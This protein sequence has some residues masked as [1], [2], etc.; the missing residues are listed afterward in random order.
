MTCKIRPIRIDGQLA[1]VPLTKGYEAVIDAADVPLVDAWIWLAKVDGRNVYA[2]RL[3][4]PR[5]GQR[6]VR[7]HRVI[8]GNPEGMQV[9]HIDCNGLNN[10]R[11]NLRVATPS[12]NQYN[13]RRAANNSS[14]AKGVYWHKGD[15]RWHAQIRANNVKYHLGVFD[16]PEKA[17]AAYV[18]ASLSLH[19]EFGR[20]E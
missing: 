20:R 1:Y 9:D 5:G 8:I 12:Q 2:A 4:G 18:A 19:G 17:H 14:G 15:G 10:R 13:K 6:T 3:E 11:N 7:M 16:T